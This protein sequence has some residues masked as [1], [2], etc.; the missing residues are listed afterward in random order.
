M[1]VEDMGL[2]RNVPG[3]IVLEPTDCAM[4]KDLL[5]QVKDIYVCMLY[6]GFCERNR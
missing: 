2:M 5:R 6:S 3:A 4:L 1:P